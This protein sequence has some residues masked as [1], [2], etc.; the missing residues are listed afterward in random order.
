MDG[1]IDDQMAN[2]Q[3][4]DVWLV[5]DWLPYLEVKSTNLTLENGGG[6]ELIEM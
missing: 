3:M 2:K 6:T 5:Q 1:E 4:D